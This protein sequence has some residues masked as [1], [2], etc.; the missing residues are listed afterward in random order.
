MK[1]ALKKALK[2]ILEALIYTES[3]YLA[4]AVFI[5][6]RDFCSKNIHWSGSDEI[7]CI[8]PYRENI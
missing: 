2:S 3:F 1:K 6:W 5:V 4:Y 7:Y 8:N